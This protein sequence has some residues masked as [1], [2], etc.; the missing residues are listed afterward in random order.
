[1]KQHTKISTQETISPAAETVSAGKHTRTQNL[2]AERREVAALDTLHSGED[3]YDQ[4]AT[5][6]AAS[7]PNLTNR[8]LRIAR[9]KNPEWLRKLHYPQNMISAADPASNEFA[10]DVAS[11]QRDLN[12][13]IDGIAGPITV[14]ALTGTKMASHEDPFSMHKIDL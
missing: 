8:Q 3:F 11:K 1:M 13:R 10:F 5:V 4:R 6:D 12:L 14:E 2:S 7:T 9:D